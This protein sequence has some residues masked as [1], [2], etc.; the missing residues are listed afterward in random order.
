MV[1]L[2]TPLKK[3]P[4]SAI[5][6]LGKDIPRPMIGLSIRLNQQFT[7]SLPIGVNKKDFFTFQIEITI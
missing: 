5:F 7:Q 1:T 6:G 3:K 2:K 4:K